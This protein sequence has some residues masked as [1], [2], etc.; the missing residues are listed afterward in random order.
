MTE[1]TKPAPTKIDMEKRTY[2]PDVI[3]LRDLGALPTAQALPRA[4]A[5]LAYLVKD[6]S[7]LES[8]VLAVLEEA[9][10]AER[11]YMARRWDDPEGSFPCRCSSGPQG[12]GP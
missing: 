7:F 10:G 3:E 9:R 1:A 11:W 5:F 6:R 8:H 4:A 2:P 12:R